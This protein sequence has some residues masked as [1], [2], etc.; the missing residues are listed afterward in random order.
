M[1]EVVTAVAWEECDAIVMVTIVLL[2]IW[3]CGTVPEHKQDGLFNIQLKNLNIW[4]YETKVADINTQKPAPIVVVEGT[5]FVATIGA[6]VA[7][8]T[9]V[10]G[11]KIGFCGKQMWKTPLYS[12]A[13]TDYSVFPVAVNGVY[14]PVSWCVWAV[15]SEP[16]LQGEMAVWSVWPCPEV[17]E[18]FEC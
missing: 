6:T 17:F 9:G 11:L 2:V 15:F 5:V 16:R 18:T 14:L 1:A 8:A 4:F 10:T 7:A 13:W 3:V 12:M